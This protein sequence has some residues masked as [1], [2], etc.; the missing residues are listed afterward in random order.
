VN[1]T[2]CVACAR[3]TK[4]YR[5]TALGIARKYLFLLVA[6]VSQAVSLIPGVSLLRD[7]RSHWFLY[8]IMV[9]MLTLIYLNAE[10]IR[11]YMVRFQVWKH[12]KLLLIGWAAIALYI[13]TIVPDN[14]ESKVEEDNIM[15][16]WFMGLYGV[17]TGAIFSHLW[18]QLVLDISGRE[19]PEQIE[20]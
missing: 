19:G 16:G 20:L 15:N 12:G 3:G 8:G 4:E 11:R 13:I 5:D 17:L 10:F 18:D 1:W 9:F 2:V 7:F 14:G 6:G